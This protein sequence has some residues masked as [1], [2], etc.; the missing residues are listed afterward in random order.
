MKK[1]LSVFLTLALA[2]SVLTLSGCKGN[3]ETDNS[4]TTINTS[5]SSV[6]TSSSEE[7]DISFEGETYFQL[8]LP[9]EGET[10]AVL[11]TNMGDISMKFFPEEAP[12][13][14]ENFITHAKDGYYDGL[15]FH[16]VINNFMIQGGDP[17]GNGTGGESI[18]GDSFED[19]FSNKL[20]N[21]YGSVAMANSG[22]NTNG[23]QFFINQMHD[24]SSI[25]WDEIK[26]TYEQTT[27]YLASL[28]DEYSEEEVD[29]I[30]NQYYTSF[31][32]PDLISDEIKALYQKFGGN[33]FL[34]GSA[35]DL[36]RGHT[37]FAQVYDGFDVVNKI[38]SVE[39][40]SENNKPLGSVVINSIDITEYKP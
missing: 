3:E 15:T 20:A 2:M 34:D 39:V 31:C 38:A 35:N 29:M 18:W 23:S 13:A 27:G 6:D 32:N 9:E 24:G 40:D 19:E 16:R 33:Y 1:I 25:S 37:V 22:P 28:T 5:N 26:S 17:V 8:T 21:L 30:K 10:I 11:H 36:G 7:I 12:K 4:S 14:V